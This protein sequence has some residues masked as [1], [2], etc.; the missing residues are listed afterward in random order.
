M[1]SQFHSV[2]LAERELE[3]ARSLRRAEDSRETVGARDFIIKRNSFPVPQS[4]PGC[5]GEG[6]GGEGL[7]LL[8]GHR[9]TAGRWLENSGS[10][11]RG[12]ITRDFK[13]MRRNI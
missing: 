2:S 3:P 6:E 7:L 9:S 4:S 8:A 5:L 1:F 10:R 13:V 11:E 12:D